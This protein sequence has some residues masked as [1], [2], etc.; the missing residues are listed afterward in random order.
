M[1][2]LNSTDDF[3]IFS[4]SENNIEFTSKFPLI[5]D[6]SEIWPNLSE[7]IKVQD[8]SQNRYYIQ[9]IEFKVTKK[10]GRGRNK[11]SKKAE[12]TASSIDNI[13]RKIQIHFLNF[14]ISFL[15]NCI[16]AYFGYPKFTFLNFSHSE[17]IKVSFEY[18]EKIKKSTIKELIEN[19][20]ISVK[21]K[22]P[23]KN[24]NT[25]KMNL[26]ALDENPWFKQIF[27]IKYLELFS[28]YYNDEQPLKEITKFGKKIL[29]QKTKSFY[30]LL[31]KYKNLEDEL[32][33][34]SKDLYFHSN[35]ERNQ[36]F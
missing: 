33:K 10:R 12:H 19:I 4:L 20:D 36:V 1:S 18:M 15:N 28:D 9:R 25:N 17:K 29:L 27:G 5:R 31:Q 22:H 16:E 34:Y 24:K 2:F 23:D 32:I 26:K 7:M 21:Y 8:I 35:D 6:D 14:V 13:E 30:Y 11:E 3:S